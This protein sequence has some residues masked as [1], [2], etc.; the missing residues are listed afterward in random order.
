[1]AKELGLPYVPI[2]PGIFESDRM[3]AYL[4]M[5]SEAGH[6]CWCLPWK[7]IRLLLW[8]GENRPNGNLGLAGVTV[9]SRGTSTGCPCGVPHKTLRDIFLKSGWLVETKGGVLIEGWDRHGGRL[10]KRRKQWRERKAKN[11]ASPNVPRDIPQDSTETSTGSPAHVPALKVNSKEAGASIVPAGAGAPAAKRNNWSDKVNEVWSHYRIY[12][13]ANKKLRLVSTEKTYQA[14]K[15]RLQE[16]W[17]VDAIKQSI[18]GYHMSEWHTGRDPR[19]NGKKYLSP[20]LLFRSSDHIHAGLGYLEKTETPEQRAFREFMGDDFEGTY[21]GDN[22]QGGVLADV[23]VIDVH[24]SGDDESRPGSQKADG[25]SL[26][27]SDEPEILALGAGQVIRQGDKAG[28]LP[29]ARGAG[30][31]SRRPGPPGEG[32][33]RPQGS[34]EPPPPPAADEVPF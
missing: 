17:S 34:R 31:D 28:P 6:E 29:F 3:G 13:P 4:D 5:M 9:M 26:V 19:T 18:D 21:P 23:R 15:A 12:H 1:M 20:G 25:R 22:P 8:A 33:S 30:V 2:D 32:S 11:R 14:I 7:V 10:L 24:L 16:D 27:R